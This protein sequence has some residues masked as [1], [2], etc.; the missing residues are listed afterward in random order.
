MSCIVLCNYTCIDNIYALLIFILEIASLAIDNSN[1]LSHTASLGTR[2][3]RSSSFLVSIILILILISLNTNVGTSYDTIIS[4]FPINISLDRV[5]I[6]QPI[7]YA[8]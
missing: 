1:I 3:W 2:I 4:T 6:H 7:F 5:H 8:Y